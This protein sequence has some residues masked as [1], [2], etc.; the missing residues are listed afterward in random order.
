MDLFYAYIIHICT[1]ISDVC[2]GSM[3]QRV[4]V[5]LK[6]GYLEFSAGMK[7]ELHFHLLTASLAQLLP[8]KQMHLEFWNPLAMDVVMYPYGFS[9]SERFH[10]KRSL[11]SACML[12][13]IM[14][15]WLQ[16]LCTWII[17]WEGN[18]LSFVRN[19]AGSLSCSQNG[20]FG[21]FRFLFPENS[22]EDDPEEEAS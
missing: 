8:H 10:H 18:I 9:S 21:N 1:L 11:H 5:F 15:L 17:K 4:D 3:V 12:I 20:V 13:C 19:I 6:L 14:L 16:S 22:N 2:Y 7:V